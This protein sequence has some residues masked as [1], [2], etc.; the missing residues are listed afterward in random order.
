MASAQEERGRKNKQNRRSVVVSRAVLRNDIT[1]SHTD[2]AREQFGFTTQSFEKSAGTRPNETT[3]R[4][5][6]RTEV[7]ELHR[8]GVPVCCVFFRAATFAPAAHGFGPKK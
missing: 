7:P 2:I 3:F 8:Q 4:K 5:R 1:N 6:L